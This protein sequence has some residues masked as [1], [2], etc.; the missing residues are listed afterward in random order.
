MQLAHEHFGV[1]TAI[2]TSIPLSSNVE[3]LEGLAAHQK[4]NTPLPIVAPTDLEVG[5]QRVRRSTVVFGMLS[6]EDEK[7]QIHW[8]KKQQF[9]TIYVVVMV[10]RP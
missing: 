1:K 10:S 7:I 2:I 4:A 5:V 9:M 3:G 8:P 6:K